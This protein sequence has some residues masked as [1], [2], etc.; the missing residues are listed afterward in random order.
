MALYDYV[1]P[2]LLGFFGGFHCVGMCGGIIA[3]VSIGRGNASWPGIA[4]YQVA[5]IAT[6]IFL[7]LVAT[8]VGIVFLKSGS[9]ADG[10]TLLTLVAGILIIVLSFQL[11]GWIPEKFGFIS[12]FIKIPPSVIR[13]VSEENSS[14]YWML[15]GIFNG[16]LPCGLVYAAMA[17][18]LEKADLINSA[19]IMFVFGLGTTPWLLGV[20]WAIKQIQPTMRNRFIKVSAVVM[21]LFGL[22]LIFKSTPFWSHSMMEM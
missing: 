7:G 15:L 5:R 3:S 16:L 13:G 11:G 10:Q 8:T 12:K 20:A 18:A 6:Y 22:F 14:Y 2:F 4:L 1:P 21:A 9:F 17:L 19:T